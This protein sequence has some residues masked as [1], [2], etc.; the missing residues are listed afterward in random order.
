MAPR[1]RDSV[2]GSTPL[3]LGTGPGTSC[4]R[5]WGLGWGSPAL[6]TGVLR[7]GS[8]FWTLG[9]WYGSIAR[10]VWDQGSGIWGMCLGAGIRYPSSGIWHR[11]SG[12]CYLVSG[13]R[14]LVSGFRQL[15][16]GIRGLSAAIWGIY[17]VLGFS[18]WDRRSG[19]SGQGT[20]IGEQGFGNQDPG[21]GGCDPEIWT[22][23]LGGWAQELRTGSC[24][25]ACGSREPA[26]G[27]RLVGMVIVSPGYVSGALRCMLR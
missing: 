16:F 2:P 8:R 7:L 4:P 1:V 22:S 12:A 25:L 18:N 15:E 24:D 9:A 17:S 27:C 20:C 19:S 13:I 6:G 5:I 3:A 11:V 14:F 26:S 10:G 21:S 23:Y